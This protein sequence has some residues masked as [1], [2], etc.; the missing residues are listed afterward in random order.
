MQGTDRGQPTC[1]KPICGNSFA[2]GGPIRPGSPPFL[3]PHEQIC[4][5]VAELKRSY[6]SQSNAF[7]VGVNL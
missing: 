7:L 1:Q 4:S 2:Q 3:V 5:S 6:A